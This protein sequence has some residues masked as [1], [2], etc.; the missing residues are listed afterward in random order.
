MGKHIGRRVRPIP[1][2]HLDGISASPFDLVDAPVSIVGRHAP[3]RR[4]LET[5][6][7]QSH[8]QA[9]A[10]RYSIDGSRVGVVRVEQ[11]CR[12]VGGELFDEQGLEVTNVAVVGVGSSA[13]VAA[14]RFL[15][16]GRWSTASIL[17]RPDSSASRRSPR[18]FPVALAQLLQE[19]VDLVARPAHQLWRRVVNI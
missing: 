18:A 17:N 8:D 4:L 15:M 14:T 10:R 6:V 11:N 2:E 5:R 13:T 19:L 1:G 9:L 12:G 16:G 3:G 7:F